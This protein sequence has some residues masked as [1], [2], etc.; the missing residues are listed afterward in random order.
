[1]LRY[2]RFVFYVIII[3][4]IPDLEKSDEF[5][6]KLDIS[7]HGIEVFIIPFTRIILLPKEN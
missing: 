7:R 3:L 4:F 2:L 1:M 6:I 5:D